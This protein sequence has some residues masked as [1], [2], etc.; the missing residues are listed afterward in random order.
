MD[1]GLDKLKKIFLEHVGQVE[2]DWVFEEV[3][4]HICRKTEIVNLK[5]RL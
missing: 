2:Y 1:L 3:K 4:M 5:C